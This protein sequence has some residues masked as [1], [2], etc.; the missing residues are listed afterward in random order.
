MALFAVH[1]VKHGRV[2]QNSWMGESAVVPLLGAWVRQRV[3]TAA[4]LGAKARDDTLQDPVGLPAAR[5]DVRCCHGVP[6]RTVS[7]QNNV[8]THNQARHAG[9]A[10]QQSFIAKCCT[11]HVYVIFIATAMSHAYA[12][13]GKAGALAF[14]NAA[15]VHAHVILTIQALSPCV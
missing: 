14:I 2:H 12:F 1:T 4:V 9:P 6:F 15:R 3:C 7:T 10:K 13:A 8:C 5:G 11:A